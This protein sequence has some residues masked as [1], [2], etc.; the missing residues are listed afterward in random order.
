MRIFGKLTLTALLM[1]FGM[2]VQSVAEGF[3][4]SST[5]FDPDKQFSI[6]KY[7]A[8]LGDPVQL[9]VISSMRV[10]F[11]VVTVT[12][13]P[14][15][16]TTMLSVIEPQYDGKPG[17][18]YGLMLSFDEVELLNKLL[19]ETQSA[20]LGQLEPFGDHHLLVGHVTEK[21]HMSG[22]VS[23]L[24][25]KS[26]TGD[27]VRIVQIQGGTPT[28]FEFTSNGIEKLIKQIAHFVDKAEQQVEATK[29]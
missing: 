1:L 22:E 21:G 26:S 27:T 17:A 29:L 15:G 25:E 5:E 23:V 2:S 24:F 16:L 13:T 3:D 9:D 28:L 20:D 6:T 4:P 18:G 7:G 11:T 14:Q 10:G 8:I 19:Y 12:P